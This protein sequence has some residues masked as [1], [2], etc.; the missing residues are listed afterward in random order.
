MIPPR[1][2]AIT[3]IAIGHRFHDK[4]LAANATAGFRKVKP[5]LDSVRNDM[6]ND[7]VIYSAINI[8][9]PAEKA[10]A[11]L[12]FLMRK[13]AAK[14]RPNIAAPNS[15]AKNKYHFLLSVRS[16]IEAAWKIDDA[17]ADIAVTSLAFMNAFNTK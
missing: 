2:G 17:L 12:F 14:P 4:P 7:M 10:E 9:K 6:V 11:V 5:V 1:I 16:V 8:A 15:S 3:K 13:A